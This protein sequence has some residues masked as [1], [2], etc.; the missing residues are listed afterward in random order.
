[1]TH[2][3]TN[4]LQ[5][6]IALFKSNI[7]QYRSNSSYDEAN[8]RVDFI[9]KFFELLSWDVRNTQGFSEQYRDVVRED[10]VLI[11]EK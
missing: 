4:P 5:E 8:I 3:K 11:K 9:D 10:K 2:D 7:K 6:L 1:M